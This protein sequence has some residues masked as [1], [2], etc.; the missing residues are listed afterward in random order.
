M[1][2]KIGGLGIMLLLFVIFSSC[3]SKNNEEK[4]AVDSIKESIDINN[5]TLV[6]LNNRLFSIPSPIQVAL[7]VKKMN[8]GF[9]KQLMNDPGKL[10]NYTT[11][12]KRALNLGVYSTNLGYLNIFEQYPDAA[13][14]FSTVR[15]LAKDLGIVDVFDKETMQ[16]I[17]K[18]ASNKDS[19]ISIIANIN[20]NADSYLMNNDR[21]NIS[22]L[23]LAGGWV[24]SL[25]LMTQ[26]DKMNKS[27]EI[28]EKIGEQKHPLENL[29]ELLRPY[30]EKQSEDLDRFIESLVD[31]AT[32]FDG[33]EIEYVYQKPSVEPDKKLTIINSTSKTVI[34][35]YQLKTIT[36]NI[37]KIRTKIIE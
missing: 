22:V 36:Q 21:N 13:K 14:Y 9:H 25:Y 29:I 2:S 28:N 17:E 35:D 33:V 32:I 5:P 34:N 8:V 37:E 11:D 12:F 18:N 30:Y 1:T 24:E 16:R 20:R 10:K 3:N 15:T 26:Y 19:L 7:M 31:L 4:N 23:I 6:K 27:G